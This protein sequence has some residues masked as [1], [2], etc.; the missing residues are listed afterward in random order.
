MNPAFGRGGAVGGGN[1]LQAGSPRVRLRIGIFRTM[2][3]GSTQPVTE[4]V[5]GIYPGEQRRPADN[6]TTFKC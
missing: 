2:A 4:M 1:A 3:L 6:H 5:R